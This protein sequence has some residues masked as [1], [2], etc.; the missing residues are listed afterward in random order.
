MNGTCSFKLENNYE[1]SYESTVK[2]VLSRGKLEK[3]NGV[4]VKV[5]LLWLNIV[6]GK[7][8]IPTGA[9]NNVG[10]CLA[11]RSG[12]KSSLAS[13]ERLQ[14]KTVILELKDTGGGANSVTLDMTD[15]AMIVITN[16]VD[17]VFSDFTA[18]VEGNSYALG[19]R[20]MVNPPTPAD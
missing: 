2:G 3:L 1:L 20:I 4:T 11:T 5:L 16:I 18:I 9:V 17:S 14:L 19:R 15:V 10:K 12:K 7:Q 6:E 8:L 13:C